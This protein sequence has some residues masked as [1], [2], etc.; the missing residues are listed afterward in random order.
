MAQHKRKL[1]DWEIDVDEIHDQR[2]AKRTKVG[3]IQIDDAT[4]A[5]L[6]SLGVT[7][8]PSNILIGEEPQPQQR[9]KPKP[10][11]I[12]V[13]PE[14]VDTLRSFGI[15]HAQ[16]SNIGTKLKCVD[17]D[18]YPLLQLWKWEWLEISSHEW[19]RFRPALALVTQ[20]LSERTCFFDFFV[21]LTHGDVIRDESSGCDFFLSYDKLGGLHRRMFDTTKQILLEMSKVTRFRFTTER[22]PLRP[23]VLGAASQHNVLMPGAQMYN[24]L[25]L[26]ESAT[27]LDSQQRLGH[28]KFP[29][30]DIITIELSHLFRQALDDAALDA[31]R[32]RRVHFTFAITIIHEICHA[33]W[34]YIRNK[35]FRE[36]LPGGG[37]PNMCLPGHSLK[38]QSDEFGR[39][40]L[41]YQWEQYH[42]VSW[43]FPSVR[44]GHPNDVG[45]KQTVFLPLGLVTAKTWAST[46]EKDLLYSMEY[47]NRFF[48][49]E[50][51]EEISKKGWKAVP[52]PKFPAE[53]KLVPDEGRDVW[54]LI[55]VRNDG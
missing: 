16:S 34:L 27:L 50:T 18:L 33:V 1:E 38:S 17:D 29:P 45:A 48:E 12:E 36:L 39:W 25:I 51:W 53:M 41:G 40:D 3:P 35:N 15:T 14:T 2:P 44:K 55:V 52:V 26:K 23:G 19:N 5:S 24:R 11:R 10:V 31:D 9:S 21:R 7:R 54:K 43:P 42:L 32:L 13:D 46:Q 28:D 49:Q 22:K 47:V 30:S 37:E 6:A 8:T 20:F 4:I